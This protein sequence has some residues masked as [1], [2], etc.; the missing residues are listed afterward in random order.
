[1][2]NYSQPASMEKIDIIIPAYNEAKRITRTLQAYARFFEPNVH[3]TVVL[4]G[5]IDNTLE[6]VQQ[7]Q[8]Q[9]PERISIINVEAA[10]GKGGAVQRGWQEVNGDYIG[11]V[12]ADGATPPEEFKKLLDA[13]QQSD[14]AIAS[15]FL[16]ES[17]VE[18]RQSP[19]RTL[20]SHSSIAL[21]KT[22]FGIPYHDTQC[23]AK[24]F[25]RA[26][27]KDVLPSLRE[28]DLL[29]DVELLWVMYRWGYT[30]EEVPTIWIDQ[31]GSAMLGSTWK[32]VTVSIRMLWSLTRI[33]FRGAPKRSV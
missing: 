5:C 9:F 31:P 27:I 17:V 26:V 4:N 25:K 16:P 24:L 30:I 2:Q 11:F 10:I 33:R 3:F 13:A 1:M 15:R 32:F 12:D 19:L 23:G 6:V 21:I 7:A 22:L 29:F 14:G 8:E 20:V 28:T 18:Q